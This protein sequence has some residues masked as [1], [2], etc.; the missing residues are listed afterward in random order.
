MYTH[1]HTHTHTHTRARARARTRT[2]IH[3]RVLNIRIKRITFASIF[4]N[5]AKKNRIELNKNQTKI[6]DSRFRML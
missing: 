4:N 3:I 2:H 6:K 5:S 1:I